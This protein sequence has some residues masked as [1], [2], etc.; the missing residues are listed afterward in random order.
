MIRIKPKKGLKVINPE[1]MQRISDDG[2]VIPKMTTHWNNRLNDGDI[3]VENI[4]KK[5]QT[6]KANDG[7]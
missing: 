1:T 2:I 7:N 3:T 5:K 6:K 4:P